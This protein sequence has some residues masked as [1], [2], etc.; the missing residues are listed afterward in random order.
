F[1]VL[2][3]PA[4]VG[5]VT[6]VGA[7]TYQV[8]R[9]YTGSPIGTG[10]ALKRGLARALPLFFAYMLVGIMAAFG[11]LAFIIGFFVVWISAFAVAPAVVLEKQGP[12]EAIS[13][14][15]QLIKGAW[16]EV[17]GVVF[18]AGLIAALPATAI[19]TGLTI[20]GV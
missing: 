12:V 20:F 2:T 19:S 18:V 5:G 17:F 14:S 7:V 15:W 11:I 10:E 4:I 8:S 16:L 3:I 9:A 6:A 13:R 1:A